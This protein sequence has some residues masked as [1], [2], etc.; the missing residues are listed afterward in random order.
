MPF[1]ADPE[2]ALFRLVERLRQPK[3]AIEINANAGTKVFPIMF[4]SSS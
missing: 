4:M 1:I 3:Y 2:G